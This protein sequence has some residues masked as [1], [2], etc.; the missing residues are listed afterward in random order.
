MVD[1]EAVAEEFFDF[2]AI[3][4]AEIG[5]DEDFRDRFLFF[6]RAEISAH[7]ILC[8]LCAGEL[9]KVNEIDRCAVNGNELFDFFLERDRGVFELK[10]NRAVF[11]FY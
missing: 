5:I 8:G 6:F 2:L 1:A 7:Q 4:R 3:R 10:W 11:G 9:G